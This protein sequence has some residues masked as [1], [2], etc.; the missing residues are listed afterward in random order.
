MLVS[1]RKPWRKHAWVHPFFLSFVCFHGI[2]FVRIG[3]LKVGEGVNLERALLPTSR[4]G[5]HLVQGHVDCT[6]TILSRIP[7][8]SSL[9]ITLALPDAYIPYCVTKGF[10]CLD[11]VSLTLTH[12]GKDKETGQGTISVMLI[13][14]TRE[15]VTLGKKRVGDKVNVEVDVVAKQVARLLSWEA[16]RKMTAAEYDI[17]DAAE[18][19][20]QGLEGWIRSIVKDEIQKQ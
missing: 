2:S 1:L 20:W 4:L 12:V 5:G 9:R 10:I 7:D 14:Y 17:D 6:A 18:K 3:E 13:E 19:G 11:G 16:T 8:E 15:K